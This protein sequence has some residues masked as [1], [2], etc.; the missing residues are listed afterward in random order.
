MLLLPSLNELFGAV[1]KE[2]LARAIHPPRLIYVLLTIAALTGAVFVGYALA[3]REKAT[4][5]T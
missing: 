1:E 5:S 4:G 2:R 3:T